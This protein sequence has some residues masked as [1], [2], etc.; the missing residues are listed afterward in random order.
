MP[1]LSQITGPSPGTTPSVVSQDGNSGRRFEANYNLYMLCA[2]FGL[3]ILGFLSIV[4]WIQCR[5]RL[6]KTD[7]H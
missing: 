7:D 1:S 5:N 3:I 2:S 4:C 6:P